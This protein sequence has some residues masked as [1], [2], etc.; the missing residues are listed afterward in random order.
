MKTLAAALLL[1]SLT[2]AAQTMRHPQP[3]VPSS[4]HSATPNLQERL[5]TVSFPVSCA[6]SQAAFNRGVALQ[7]D[8]WYDEDL[9][10]FQQIVKTDPA[11]AMAHWGVAMSVFHQIWDRPDAD[12]MKFGWAEMQ[13]AQSLNAGTDRERAYIAALAD[14]YR[15]GDKKYQER[16][17]AYSAAMGKLYEKYPDDVDA[18][19]FYALSLL[20]ARTPHNTDLDQQRKAMAVLNPLF[21]KYPDNPGVVHYIIHACDNPAM[22]ADGLAAANHYGEIAPSGPHAFHMP[23][24]IYARLGLWGQDIASQVGS[25]DASQAA[26]ARGES[27]LMDEPHSYDFLL[28]AYLQSGQDTKARAVLTDVQVPLNKIAAMSG[29]MSSYVPMYRVKLPSFYAL[30]MRD[31]KAAA[32]TEPIP[33]AAPEMTTQVYWVRA[34]ADGHLKQPKQ[35]RA[36]LA[37][38]DDLIAEIKKG[39]YAYLAEGTSNEIERGEI[40]A[41]AY[42]AEGKEQ[43]AFMKINAAAELQ[44]KVGQAEVDIPAREM[45]GDMLLGFKKPK[46]AL[47]EYEVSLRHSPNR[48]NGLYGAGRAAEAA[49]D[50]TKAQ[51]YY[52]ALLKSTNNGDD[53][54]RPEFAHA[55]SFAASSQQA[56]N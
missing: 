4:P 38:Y 11:C 50:K 5:G 26:E 41:W 30:E 47:A 2:L 35:A 29:G 21:A 46:E 14:F 53:S 10:Q 23:G 1:A 7:H 51:L 32:A 15:P 18:G 28:Y 8:F 44:D 17:D 6:A 56:A 36:D 40:E 45:L 3:M 43:D 20:A 25:I 27:G 54:A 16:I 24:H 52:A 9:P 42:Y 48:L 37:H 33:G 55:K 34:I 19:A 13:K 22:A 31:W 49:G 12:T 39:S